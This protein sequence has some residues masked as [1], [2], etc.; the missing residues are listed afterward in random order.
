MKILPINMEKKLHQRKR[1]PQ[2]IPQITNGNSSQGWFP[3]G[4]LKSSHI[5]KDM[6]YHIVLIYAIQIK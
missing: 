2:S 1:S 6:I 3:L 4:G 5:V